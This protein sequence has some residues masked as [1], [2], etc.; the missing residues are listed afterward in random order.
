MENESDYPRPSPAGPWLRQGFTF[1][2]PGPAGAGLIAVALAPTFEVLIALAFVKT[3]SP[4]KPN[5]ADPNF[6]SAMFDSRVSAELARLSI[7]EYRLW[8]SSWSDPQKRI[9]RVEARLKKA[10]EFVSYLETEED[11]EAE[12]FGLTPD[13]RFMNRVR[14]SLDD[15]SDE[16]R[17][18]ANRQRY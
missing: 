6:S 3:T 17:R 10:D 8:E 18:S 4:A 12:L 9:D 5:H 2:R 7:E 15:E 14:F 11:R 16:V 1:L 13:E